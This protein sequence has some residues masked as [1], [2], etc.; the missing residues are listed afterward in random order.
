VVTVEIENIA[1]NPATNLI[2]VAHFGPNSVSVI[3]GSIN[4]V[5]TSVTFNINPTNQEV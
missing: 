1:V 4:N 3:D 2:Y 5:V